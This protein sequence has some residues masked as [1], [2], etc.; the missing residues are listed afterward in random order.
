MVFGKYLVKSLAWLVAIGG[1]GLLRHMDTAVG[2][3]SALQRLVRLK[4]HHLLQILHIFLNISRAIS[5]KPGYDLCLHI[6]Y[7]AFSTLFFL[8][9]LQSA[10]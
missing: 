2:H 3:K 7:S 4:A 10:P 9:F 1:A 8:K 6:Q 5:R